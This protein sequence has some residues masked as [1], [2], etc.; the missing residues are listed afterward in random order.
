MTDQHE[1]DSPAP[2]NGQGNDPGD[3]S[4]TQGGSGGIVALFATLAVLGIGI[5]IAF[6]VVRAILG[7]RPSDPTSERIQSLIE[8]ANRLLKELDDKK[9]A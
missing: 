6:A 3:G 2:L 5:A 1:L 4:G 9:P 8:E 7:R